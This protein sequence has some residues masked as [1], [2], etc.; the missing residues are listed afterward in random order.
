MPVL[1]LLLQMRLSRVHMAMVVDEFGGIDGR[2]L[3]M[4]GLVICAMGLLF[5]LTTF[6]NPR[7]PADVGL[8]LTSAIT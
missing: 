4:G 6:T 7:R 2:S 3:L 5:G 8:T 1:D